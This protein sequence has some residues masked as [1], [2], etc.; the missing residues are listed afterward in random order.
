MDPFKSAYRVD[1]RQSNRNQSLHIDAEDA[2]ATLGFPKGSLLISLKKRLGG[3]PF[4]DMIADVLQGFMNHAHGNGE[5]RKDKHF[6]GPI[7]FLVL[8]YVDRM[9]VV[10]GVSIKCS[11]HEDQETFSEVVASLNVCEHL[12]LDI[13]V[14]KLHSVF[15]NTIC[16]PVRVIVVG[17]VGSGYGDVGIFVNCG[18]SGV[19]V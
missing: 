3:H 11:F 4:V 14:K 13:S 15:A 10:L 8:C 9:V 1:Q 19:A 7:V 12:I 6:S 18:G 17:F 2:H 5:L 16:Y